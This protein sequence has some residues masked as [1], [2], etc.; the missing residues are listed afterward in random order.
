M[1]N[2]ANNDGVRCVCRHRPSVETWHYPSSTDRFEG[3]HQTFSG[4]SLAEATLPREKHS[5]GNAR[6]SMQRSATDVQ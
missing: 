1:K 6:E 3:Q 2:F 4:P 5:C